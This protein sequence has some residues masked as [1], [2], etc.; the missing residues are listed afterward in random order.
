MGQLIHQ[1]Q[2]RGPPQ[3]GV[4]IKLPQMDAPVV[5]LLAGKLLQALQQRQG[6]RTRM[7]FHITDDRVNS[8]FFRLVRGLQHGI[9]FADAC[10]ISEK[11]LQL[12]RQLCLFCRFQIR[13]IFVMSFLHVILPPPQQPIPNGCRAQRYMRLHI[14]KKRI[15]VYL[16]E[17]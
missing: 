4:Q 16:M 1:D 11:D 8:L 10:R 2:L 17:A 9:C 15:M 6:V 14:F 12:P 7:P 13:Q 5:D 3:R